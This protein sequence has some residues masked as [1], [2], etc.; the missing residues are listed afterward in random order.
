MWPT[1]R[2]QDSYERTSWPFIEKM[3]AGEVQAQMTLSRAAKMAG[4]LMPGADESA[5]DRKRSGKAEGSW[6]LR[7]AVL[8]FGLLHPSTETTTEQE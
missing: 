6:Q 2:A 1:A 7:E 3:A 5:S 8:A 4:W